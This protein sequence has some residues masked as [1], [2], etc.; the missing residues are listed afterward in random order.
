MMRCA[1][2]GSTSVGASIGVVFTWTPLRKKIRPARS[3]GWIEICGLIALIGIVS[4][5]EHVERLLLIEEARDARHDFL[6]FDFERRGR[7]ASREFPATCPRR[8]TI[9]PP[10]RAGS[11]AARSSSSSV[12]LGGQDDEI[13]LECADFPGLIFARD[14]FQMIFAG[15]EDH[16]TL[17]DEVALAH[18]R[19]IV[20]SSRCTVIVSR[21]SAA[22]IPDGMARTSAAKSNSPGF[23][24]SVLGPIESA[25][26]KVWRKSERRPVRRSGGRAP[27]RRRSAVRRPGAL[28]FMASLSC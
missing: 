10:Q 8:R 3:G 28:E 17:I 4:L 7:Q 15:G 24:R 6:A 13:L 18:L 21:N 27:S 20:C 2:S 12:G 14:K 22:D 16:A 1:F 19:E 9:S 25:A 26:M 23:A 5:E 11:I